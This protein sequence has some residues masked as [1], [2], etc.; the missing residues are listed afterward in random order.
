MRDISN[1]IKHKRE[2]LADEKLPEVTA[3][4]YA[5]CDGTQVG[6]EVVF[7][8]GAQRGL[9][10]GLENGMDDGARFVGE[11]DEMLGECRRVGLERHDRVLQTIG[12]L[13]LPQ[14]RSDQ[15]RQERS[16]SLPLDRRFCAEHRDGGHQ[17]AV[18][19]VDEF[20]LRPASE[21]RRQVV[22]VLRKEIAAKGNIPR[23]DE[24][25]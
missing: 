1:V 9:D 19:E 14:G 15:C 13:G 7:R 16:R 21:R 23:D 18:D 12:L 20:A 3:R 8:P 6:I 11:V 10:D 4:P 25:R 2:I 5:F 24:V 17:A 22:A